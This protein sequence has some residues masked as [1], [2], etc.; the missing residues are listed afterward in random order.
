MQ[1]LPEVGP[2]VKIQGAL[3]I[4]E[5]V[6][7]EAGTVREKGLSW[8]FYIIHGEPGLSLVSQML[9]EWLAET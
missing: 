9:L 7:W 3:F 2:D 4:E 5:S 1:I 6:S 8:D